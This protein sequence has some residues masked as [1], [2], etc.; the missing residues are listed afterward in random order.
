MA[1]HVDYKIRLMVISGFV[2]VSY[3]TYTDCECTVVNEVK[4][5]LDNKGNVTDVKER[6]T[7]KERQTRLVN[8][9]RHLHLSSYKLARRRASDRI[10]RAKQRQGP[11][12][13]VSPVSISITLFM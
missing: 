5:G 13:G 10:R 4:P 12:E 11:R 9:C 3:V 6:E 1:P 2:I 7:N 8:L